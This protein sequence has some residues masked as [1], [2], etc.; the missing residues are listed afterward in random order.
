MT[1][2]KTLHTFNPLHVLVNK[3]SVSNIDELKVFKL[4][5]HPEIRPQVDVMK[6]E[7]KKYQALAGS[8]KSFEKRKDIKGKDTFDLSDW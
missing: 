3:I 5:D 7:V 1:R 2:M 6:T 8:I 4:Y